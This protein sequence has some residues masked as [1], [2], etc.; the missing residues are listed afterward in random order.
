[1][2]LKVRMVVTAGDNWKRG[3]WAWPCSAFLSWCWLPG[4][5]QC[6]KFANLEIYDSYTSL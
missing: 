6:V 2:G 4:Y 1:M 3:F 5:T